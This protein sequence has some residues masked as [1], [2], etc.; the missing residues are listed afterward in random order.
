MSIVLKE[1]NSLMGAREIYDR[2]QKNRKTTAHLYEET[3]V[4]AWPRIYRTNRRVAGSS[5]SDGQRR[6]GFHSI[7]A[8]IP[9]RY[10][11]STARRCKGKEVSY[12]RKIVTSAKKPKIFIHLPKSKSLTQILK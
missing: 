1:C 7:I 3:Y 9:N 5:I 8:I 11:H 12:G 2:K 4:S 6:L 10:R